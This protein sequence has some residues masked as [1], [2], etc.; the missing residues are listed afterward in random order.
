MIRDTMAIPFNSPA[1]TQ[2]IK[3]ACSV[4]MITRDTLYTALQFSVVRTRL[5]TC[6]VRALLK[7]L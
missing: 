7:R 2:G 5:K 1:P 3:A 6:Q 4:E